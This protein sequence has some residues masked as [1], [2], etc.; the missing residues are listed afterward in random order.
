MQDYKDFI[1]KVQK[2]QSPKKHLITNSI[3][4][5]DIYKYLRKNKWPNISR[6]LKE[7]EFYLIIRTVNKYLAK[8]LSKGTEIKLP[9]RLGS[10]EVRK[11]PSRISIVN[12]KVTT[13]LPVNWNATLKLWYEDPES[14]NNKTLVRL[15]YEEIFRVYYNKSNAN[16]NNKSFYEFRPI[17]D[18]KK[19]ITRNIK[20]GILDA[21][22]LYK[23]D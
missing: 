9:Y 23:Y 16:Y 14:Y 17:R 20:Q 5:Y 11:R 21:F 3:G 19:G 6:P 12:G 13:N 18:I 22:S 15:E 8:E 4:V 10:L 2:L 1:A 7:K